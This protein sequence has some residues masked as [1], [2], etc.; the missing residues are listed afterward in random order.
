MTEFLQPP[1]T[2]NFSV[3]PPPVQQPIHASPSQPTQS[4]SAPHYQNYQ[5]ERH[6]HGGFSGQKPHFRSYNNFRGPNNMSQDDFDGKRLRK[7]VMRKTVDYNSSIVREL[8]V[9]IHEQIIV[10]LFWN[11]YLTKKNMGN[12]RIG[13][14]N[15]TIVI[16]VRY[17]QRAFMCQKC[18]HRRVTWIIQ[19]MQ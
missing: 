6:Y 1:P 2:T 3:P 14:G 4:P 9:C 12:C 10:L 13:Y 18:F 16:V 11:H 5:R 19:S 8:E 15:E 17:S 7:S